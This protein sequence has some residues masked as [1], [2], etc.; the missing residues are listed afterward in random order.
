[1]K[2]K[3]SLGSLKDAQLQLA[4]NPKSVFMRSEM[5]PEQ[6]NRRGVLFNSGYD[7]GARD[8][9]FVQKTYGNVGVYHFLLWLL[10]E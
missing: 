2:S 5:N 3:I 7:L 1:M 9:G 10:E 8:K 4:H 6:N